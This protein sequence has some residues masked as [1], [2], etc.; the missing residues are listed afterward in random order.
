MKTKLLLIIFL[1]LLANHIN[2]QQ[3][4]SG[5][6][7]DFVNPYPSGT[8]STTSSSWS[9]VNGGNN[10]NAG[11]WT[12]FNVTS[13]NT[14]EWSYCEDFGG[15]S[16]AWD[17]QLTLFNNK[18]LKTPLCFST[19]DC[20][21]NGLAPYL[22][23]KA[24]FT[25]VVRVLST[26]YKNGT[27]CQS[28]SGSPYNKLVWRQ[29]ASASTGYNLT[30]TVNNV[31]GTTTMSGA[32]VKLYNSDYSSDLG[33]KTANSSG[34]VVFTG[35]I[36]GNY[37]YEVYYTPS[38]TNPPIT[39]Q[40][41]WGAK[42]V[43]ISGSAKSDS[44]TRIQPYMS[45]FLPYSLTILTI[46]QQTT[47]NF[48]VKNP[49]GYS[50]SSYVKV[51]VDRSQTS[52]Y[53]YN[54]T[55]SSKS[56]SS[57]S[58]NTF[59]VPVT[60]TI[61]G[62]YYAY[63]FVYST[64]SNGNVVITDQY[65]WKEV[66]TVTAPVTS[67]LTLTVKNIDGATRSNAKIILYNSSYNELSTL[68]TNSSGQATFSNLS[69]GDYNYEIYYTPTT[70]N[71]P[72]SNEEFWGSGTVT[73]NNS[74]KSVS[75]TRIQPYISSAPM[76]DPIELNTG[77]QT[78]GTFIVK[79]ALGYSSDNTYVKVWI[80]R[81]TTS[82]WDYVISTTAKSFATGT[83]STFPFNVTPTNSGSYNCYA[84]VYNNVNGKPVITDQYNWVQAFNV[85]TITLTYPTGGESWQLARTKTITWTS[86]ANMN[87]NVNIEINGN[88]PSGAWEPLAMNIPNSGS[89]SYIV[90]GT[91][92]AAKRI[93]ITAVNNATIN[94]FSN[95]FS[96]TNL[97][98]P[99]NSE[100]F[101]NIRDGKGGPQ[102]S[103]GIDNY[104]SSSSSSVWVDD[105]DNLHLKLRKFADIWYCSQISSVKSFGYGE[106]TFKINSRVDQLDKNIVLGLFTYELNG[107]T[108]TPQE[109]EIDIEFSKWAWNFGDI[110]SQ[111]V[112][113]YRLANTRV[114]LIHP[115]RFKTVLNGDY[116]THKFIWS[117]GNIKFQ[118]YHGHN[119]N[120]PSNLYNDTTYSDPKIPKEGKE[121]VVLNLYLTGS[122]HPNNNQETEEIIKSFTFKKINTSITE[123]STSDKIIIYPNPTTGR[124]EISNLETLGN[125]CKVDIF[126]Y[127]G[128]LIYTSTYDN[129]GNNINLDVSSYPNGMYIIKLSNN[130]INCM[131]KVVKN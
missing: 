33:T 26:A 62:T 25:G 124:F 114:N 61:A 104:W 71:P 54:G 41:F 32:T 112:Y 110:N 17:A 119:D 102:S 121:V 103:E 109:K 72:V 19:D 38:G 37:N 108:K 58:S 73:I 128:M 115:K 36:N 63:A 98:W 100:I 16:T 15:V 120:L 75:F 107:E 39:N 131:K 27:G 125:K 31:D 56:M 89:Y 7:T 59:T 23:W 21:T 13:G 82:P 130:G 118:S 94:S 68:T 86:S 123:V 12:L 126:N 47:G 60:P 129:I 116:S 88:Y 9:L 29:S 74:S 1:F 113:Q 79:N 50:Q 49:L 20:G 69:N 22:S 90:G 85:S 14:Y 42:A 5:G 81:N 83:S 106:Y 67:D 44:F 40:E 3:C 45:S 53:D 96:F 11:N 76:F 30:I 101:W 91:V 55:S 95:S 48:T 70:T 8:F 77:Q 10:M 2:S 99:L 18:N 6:C 43:T 80:D 117:D 105:E 111:Y 93:R 66:F 84:F 78:S 65:Q 51:Y 24:T 97:E 87:G 35:L 4:K 57:G 127:L 46:G 52:S 28:N 64:L 34:K 122:D 92:G